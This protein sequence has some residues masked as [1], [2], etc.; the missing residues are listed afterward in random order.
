MRCDGFLAWVFHNVVL[1]AWLHLGLGL[2]VSWAQHG[3]HGPENG[4]NTPPNAQGQIAPR[5]Q[6]LGRH[7]F[8]VKTRS[9]RAQEF[10]NQGINLSYGFNH[11][12]AMRAF[13]EVARLDPQCAMAYWGQALVLGPNINMPMPPEAEPEAYK[14]MQKALELKPHADSRE[15]AY[16]DALA[17]R[18]SGD[19][20]PDRKTLDR[21]YADAMKAVSKRYPEDLDAATLYA[22]ALM[23]LRPWNYWTRD[24]QPYAETPEILSTLESVMKRNPNHPGACHFYIHAVEATKSP[25]LA[26]AAADRL[27]KL[28]PGAGHMVHMPSHIYYRVGRYA[29]ASK[30]NAQASAVDEEYIAQCRAQG[31]YPLTYY[32]HN[33]HF[34]YAAASLEGNGELAILAAEKVAAAIPHHALKDFPMLQGFLAIPDF[35]LARFGRWEQILKLPAPAHDTLFLKGV[36][37]YVR[38][39][40]LAATGRLDEATREM[41]ALRG[42]LADKALDNTP[43]SFSN[44]S[45]RGILSIA[46][47]VLAGELAARRGDFGQAVSHMETGVRLEDALVYIEPPDWYFPVRQALGAVLLQA[48]RP[49]E[50]EVVYWEDLRRYPHNGWSLFGLLQSLRAQERNDEGANI[51]Q[52]FNKAW[53]QADVKLTASRF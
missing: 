47:E 14:L 23:D 18:Y 20:K 52:R 12:E 27:S 3:P 53:A 16:I 4:Q 13:R 9:K 15:R 17:K 22:E 38:G 43:A 28:M 11:A 10:F 44:N 8:R 32:P 6:N 5:L 19:A 37:H 26:E 25:E 33:L 45:A 2:C 39:T 7:T 41:D 50:A 49:R 21:A 48:G 46:P 30:S 35:A 36:R 31:I 42:I 34:L 51:E 40:A 1:V 29:D 24:G